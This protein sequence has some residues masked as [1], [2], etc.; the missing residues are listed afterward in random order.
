ME[1][2]GTCRRM[3][4]RPAA[5]GSSFFITAINLLFGNSTREDSLDVVVTQYNEK[6]MLQLSEQYLSPPARHSG[7]VTQSR[8]SACQPERDHMDSYP[9]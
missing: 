4:L 7:G 8:S 6:V 3:P 5:L 1:G 9:E 2:S